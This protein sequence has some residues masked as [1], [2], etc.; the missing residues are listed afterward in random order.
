MCLGFLDPDQEFICTDPEKKTLISAALWLLYD[1][2][3]LKNDINVP[4]KK[5]K[6]K[7]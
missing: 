5:K 3:S 2:L 4:S 6:H 7:N 1:F